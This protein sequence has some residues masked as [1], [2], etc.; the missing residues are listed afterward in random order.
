MHYLQRQL[1]QSL[2]RDSFFKNQRYKPAK[3][4][5]THSSITGIIVIAQSFCAPPSFLPFILSSSLKV[6]DLISSLFSKALV[7]IQIMYVL[8]F[9]LI[10]ICIHIDKWALCVQAS[11]QWFVFGIYLGLFCYCCCMQYLR[12]NSFQK[13]QVKG[14]E[15]LRQHF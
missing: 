1:M 6:M 11:F 9:H 2:N 14:F 10:T 3:P 7:L 13:C 8:C 5:T 15:V 4:N 12:L